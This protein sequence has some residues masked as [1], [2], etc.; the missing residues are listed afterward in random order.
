MRLSTTIMLLIAAGDIL[1][2]GASAQSYPAKPIRVIT[3]FSSGTAVDAVARVIGKRIGDAMGQQVVIDNRVGAGGS[4]GN[5][6][7]ARRTRIK[8]FA[9]RADPADVC[10]RF[11]RRSP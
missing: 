3:P 9:W 8:R 1:P 10:G 4:I 11:Q 5:V 6:A 7:A 2:M